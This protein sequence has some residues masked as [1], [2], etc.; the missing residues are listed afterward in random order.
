MKKKDNDKI[1]KSVQ[2]SSASGLSRDPKISCQSDETSSTGN[3]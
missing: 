1:K 2:T 3:R